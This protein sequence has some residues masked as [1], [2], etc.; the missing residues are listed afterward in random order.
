MSNAGASASGRAYG[1]YA[2][3]LDILPIGAGAG[4]DERRVE[5]AGQPV[6]LGLQQVGASGAAPGGAPS[7]QPQN[8][9]LNSGVG[10]HRL[11]IRLLNGTADVVVSHA[12]S[13]AQFPTGT[14]CNG[15]GPYVIGGALIAGELVTTPIVQQAVAVNPI[16]L[17]SIS[18]DVS[19][20]IDAPALAPLGT[21]SIVNEQIVGG[22]NVIA[23]NAL[24]LYVLGPNNPLG[25]PVGSSL[26]ISGS[27][28]GTS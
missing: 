2:N 23:V 14:P 15:T 4:R 5:V 7:A 26:I 24:H 16:I 27:V 17:P 22:G 6:H 13:T 21:A 8:G 1:V 10:V 19:A 12:E 18:G 20:T 9:F 25:L 11:H 3:V 28:A